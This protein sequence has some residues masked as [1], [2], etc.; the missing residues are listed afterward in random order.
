MLKQ[1]HIQFI[2]FIVIGLLNTLVDISVYYVLT[3][4]VD[5]FE[6]HLIGAKVI[7][8]AL[9]SLCSFILNR[10]W[11]F[12]SDTFRSV[13]IQALRFYFTVV[14]SLVLNASVLYLGTKI[15]N[16]YDMFAVICA[17]GVVVIFNFIVYKFWV[18]R[19]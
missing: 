15:L 6:S 14:I 3:R 4:F 16:L 19:S 10:S 2:R 18:F 17:T 7:S 13:Y 11:V 5:F 1:H 12:T 9:G 8:F